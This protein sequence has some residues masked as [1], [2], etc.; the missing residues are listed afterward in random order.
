MHLDDEQLQRLLHSQLP[1]RAARNARDH[2]AECTEC[3]ERFVSAQQDESR[4]LG[5]LRQV[6]HAV[7]LVD[8][9]A[10]AGRLRWTTPAW[11]RWA[12][13]ILLVLGMA[14]AAFA[15]PGSPVPRWFRSA[16]AWVG[17]AELPQSSGEP[18]PAAL[19]A[20]IAAVP[21]PRFVIAFESPEPGG[22]ARVTLSDGAQV[23]VRAPSGAAGYTSTPTRLVIANAG[24]GAR[25]DITIP[26]KAPRVEIRVAGAR[27]F[28]KNGT[29]ITAARPAGADGAYLIPLSPGRP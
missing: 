27:V 29:R 11:G 5:L 9:V 4:I 15:L 13:G 6:D 12:A 19:M 1:S 18:D 14:G 7:P 8:P 16:V 2:L 25:F 21:G 22:E 10:L 3:R 17:G 26:R 24:T 20:G 28:L 23:T